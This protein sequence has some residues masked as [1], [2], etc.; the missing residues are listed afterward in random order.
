MMNLGLIRSSKARM[1]LLCI[2]LKMIMNTGLTIISEEFDHDRFM[3]IHKLNHGE[4]SFMLNYDT[5]GF[6]D[7]S[8]P[9]TDPPLETNTNN[10]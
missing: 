1:I 6:E 9:T 8:N 4:V 7:S 10:A 3:G 5:Y 2:K